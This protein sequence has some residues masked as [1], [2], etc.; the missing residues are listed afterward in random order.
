MKEA[1][2]SYKSIKTIYP[3]IGI[4]CEDYWHINYKMRDF[5]KKFDY[6]WDLKRKY[7]DYN[8]SYDK[9]NVPLYLGSNGMNYYSSIF[10]GHYAIGAYQKFLDENDNHAKLDFI[11]IADWF[12]NN[13]NSK[14]IWINNYPMDTFRLYDCWQSG[15]SQAKGISTLVRAYYLTRDV[16]Y[17]NTIKLAIKSFFTSVSD[18][19]V[20]INLNKCIFFEEYT[21]KSPSLVLNGHIFAIWALRDTIELFKL[22][23]LDCTELLDFYNKVTVDLSKSLHLWDTGRWTKYDLWDEHYNIASLFYHDLHIKQLN[24]L[25]KLTQLE[26]FDIY[27]RKWLSY[28]KNPMVRMISLIEKVKFRLVRL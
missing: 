1:T 20:Q 6:Y 9:N 15:L 19:G 26:E 23:K 17:L 4:N 13:I 14:G 3:Y 28:R 8:G 10:L 12:V 7:E 24:I 5:S 11:R 2:N 22:F 27:S 16:R 18:G 25:Y 21:T